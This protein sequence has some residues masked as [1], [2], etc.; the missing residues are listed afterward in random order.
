[1]KISKNNLNFEINDVD[2]TAKVIESRNAK[3]DVLI[4]TFIINNDKKYIV[5]S[6]GENAFIFNS[7]IKSINFPSD[8]KVSLIEKNAF[9]NS[10]LNSICFSSNIKEFKEGWCNF[11]LR[12][13]NISVSPTNRYIKCFD[14]KFLLSKTNEKG[15]E[16]DNI[17]FVRR[18][19]ENEVA[20][21]D[22]VTRISPFSFSFC[23]NLKSIVFSQNSKLNSI[24]INSFS[25]SRI[26]SIVFPSTLQS[27]DEGWCSFTSNLSKVFISPQ[28]CHFSYI[29]GNCVV[30]DSILIFAPRNIEEVS[31][32]SSI[33]R[34]ASNSFSQCKNLEKVLFSNDSNLNSIGKEAFLMASIEKITIPSSVTQIEESA[35]SSCSK[36]N[37]VEFQLNCRISS[38][39][40]NLFQFTNIQCISIPSKVTK[41]CQGAFRH[42]D[43]LKSIEIPI[44]SELCSIEK[45]AFAYSSLEKICFPSK[46][47][48][49]E[50]DW[51]FSTEKLTNIS[52]SPMN[53]H[54]KYFENKFL[55]K[56]SNEKIE[57][58]D[59]LLFAR[60]D[61]D[62]KEL[63]I[64]EFIT[65]IAPFS[66]S[67]CK[68]LKSIKFPQNSMLTSIDEYAFGKSSIKAIE[69][70][71]NVTK[72]DV[73]AFIDCFNLEFIEFST[74]SQLQTIERR[75]FINTKVKKIIVPQNVEYIADNV[76]YQS[77]WL[78]SAEF[79]STELKIGS[80]CFMAAMK[81]EVMSF[82]NLNKITIG[83]DAFYELSE[84][85]ILFAKCNA[86]FLNIHIYN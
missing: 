33:K 31:I 67:F 77:V 17:I 42:C 32:P 1:M 37:C 24:E 8:S 83:K 54:I 64:P 86:V 80:G 15:E 50:K 20:I 35:F 27:L 75:A 71:S 46:M 9:F 23:L 58:F 81:M 38:I 41:I 82:P 34:I 73:D 28:N 63:F 47:S 39:E 55:L 65:R 66:F 30:S 5:S 4:P 61:I 16:F 49:F 79:L 72:I 48:E 14:N 84:N 12:L 29:E 11:V 22:F 68:R 25:S 51:C 62:E 45:D 52:V 57:K 56:K 40:K 53:K 36:L 6:I 76:F 60:R 85:F 2:F 10:S 69:I 78:K 44:D 59:I 19:I 70:P 21:P 3:D 13:N 18:D 7:K 43:K 26:E 74:N